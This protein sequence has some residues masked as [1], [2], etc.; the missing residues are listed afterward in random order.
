[1]MEASNKDWIR[2]NKKRKWMG[3]P[4]NWERELHDGRNHQEKPQWVLWQVRSL[5]IKMPTQQV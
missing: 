5:Q 3:K 4:H 2:F 1:M